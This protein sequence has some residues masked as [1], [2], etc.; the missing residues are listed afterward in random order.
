MFRKGERWQI[1]LKG[2]GQTPYARTHDGRSVLRSS[3]REMV[4]SEAC[5]HLGIPTT[6]AAALVGKTIILRG[7]KLLKNTLLR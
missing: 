4:A 7:Y 6:R 3:I 5:Y 2:S 1:Q